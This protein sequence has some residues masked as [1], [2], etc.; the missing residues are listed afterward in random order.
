MAAVIAKLTEA[1]RLD[2]W[3]GQAA[4]DLAQQ[5]ADAPAATLSARAAA[6]K[7]LREAMALALKG[8]GAPTSSV[9]EI[10]DELARRRRE[11]AQGAV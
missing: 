11:R 6:N 4:L 3:E 8:V 1:D 5:M 10:R 2:T 7:E 9:Q